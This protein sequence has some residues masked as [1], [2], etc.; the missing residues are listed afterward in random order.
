MAK[1][2]DD[3][4]RH[5]DIEMKIGAEALA[6]FAPT[7]KL[8]KLS[9]PAANIHGSKPKD[10]LENGKVVSNIVDTVRNAE[11]FAVETLAASTPTQKFEKPSL[12][13][14]TGHEYKPTHVDKDSKVVGNTVDL[15]R[16]AALQRGKER[17]DTFQRQRDATLAALTPTQKFEKMLTDHAISKMLAGGDTLAP[18]GHPNT[19]LTTY[20]EGMKHAAM[21]EIAVEKN[22][23]PKHAEKV[24]AVKEQFKQGPVTPPKKVQFEQGRVTP[25]QRE[26]VTPAKKEVQRATWTQNG[27]REPAHLIKIAMVAV[28]LLMLCTFIQIIPSLGTIMSAICNVVA[29]CLAL[30]MDCTRYFWFGTWWL[31]TAPFLFF[32]YVGGLIGGMVSQAIGPRP[33][34]AAAPSDAPPFIIEPGPSTIPAIQETITLWEIL[35][36]EKANGQPQCENSVQISSELSADSSSGIRYKSA[37]RIGN[38]GWRTESDYPFTRHNNSMP[39]ADRCEHFVKSFQHFWKE[40]MEE[41]KEKE[42]KEG[43]FDLALGNDLAEVLSRYCK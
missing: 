11:T 29:H 9:Q 19:R 5:T 10:V 35:G 2:T 8:H 32:G 43:M 3:S 6:A 27:D 15:N 14:L 41:K 38:S 40:E 28:G 7:Q 24:Q 42:E 20:L 21:P 25:Q 26:T 23:A 33:G 12:P 34:H 30:F 39:E 37:H 4:N 31:I 22:A 18:A 1:N 16:L 36:K 13:A 17:F